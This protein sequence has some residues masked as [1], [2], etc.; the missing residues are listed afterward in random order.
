MAFCVP[1]QESGLWNNSGWYGKF[2]LEM[3]W[4][5]GAHYQLWGR[6]NLFDR[7][8]GWYREILPEARKIAER[9]GS[10]E[11][12]MGAIQWLPGNPVSTGDNRSF[13][14]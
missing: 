3:H 14:R 13:W 8:L 1:P 5:H 7:S 9:Q 4:W 6:W 10:D 12:T 11:G 2:H